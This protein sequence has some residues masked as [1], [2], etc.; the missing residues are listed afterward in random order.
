M[1]LVVAVS[2]PCRLVAAYPPLPTAHRRRRLQ[3]KEES[4]KF[5]QDAPVR[6]HTHATHSR[7]CESRCRRCLLPS[8]Q[9]QTL[10]SRVPWR[11]PRRQSAAF[12]FPCAA[13]R[14][15]SVLQHDAS[16]IHTQSRLL[17]ARRCKNNKEC[18]RGI[19]VGGWAHWLVV[20]WAW[21]LP[22]FG[23]RSSSRSSIV[24]SAQTAAPRSSTRCKLF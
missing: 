4:S 2:S 1:R 15:C 13:V 17:S 3:S 8:P 6:L 11:F 7:R 20:L 24:R 5:V 18:G 22:R 14:C 19:P 21:T 12:S 23:V 9:H 10:L 16:L